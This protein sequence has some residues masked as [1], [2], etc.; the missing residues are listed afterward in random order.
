MHD[1][2]IQSEI[3]RIASVWLVERMAPTDLIRTSLYGSLISAFLIASKAD[4][5][6]NTLYLCSAV[7]GFSFSW[8]YG[9]LYL[10]V[11]EHMDVVV[12]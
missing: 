9:S 5:S 2:D 10:W 8:I 3:I 7:F 1:A 11:A 12:R 4:Q 6:A